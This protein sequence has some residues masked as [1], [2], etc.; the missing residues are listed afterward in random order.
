MILKQLNYMKPMT[1]SLQ[2]MLMTNSLQIMLMTNSL[3]IMLM[4]NSLQ[5][6]NIKTNIFVYIFCF[7][8]MID[9]IL[10]R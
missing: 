3:Q 4:T 5:I 10:T 6:A 9:L 1:N 2:I 8:N 7:C